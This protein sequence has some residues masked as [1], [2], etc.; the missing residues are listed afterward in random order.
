[1]TEQTNSHFKALDMETFHSLQRFRDAMDDYKDKNP[2]IGDLRQNPAL[3]SKVYSK[4][5][6]VDDKLSGMS[7]SEKSVYSNK[8]MRAANNAYAL[9]D[10]GIEHYA[11]F[12]YNSPYSSKNVEMI[13]SG[14]SDVFSM[15]GYYARVTLNNSNIS[16]N[17]AKMG[18]GQKYSTLSEFG[19][20]FK[21]DSV[22]LKNV[23]GVQAC[24]QKTDEGCSITNIAFKADVVPIVWVE[25]RDIKFVGY[26]PNMST[27]KG[28][29]YG[30]LTEETLS[31]HHH[32]C[33]FLMNNASQLHSNAF[34]NDT[35]LQAVREGK[36]ILAKMA[37][38][39]S[40]EKAMPDMLRFPYAM[41]VNTTSAVKETETI[42]QKSNPETEN[43][44][45]LAT[46]YDEHDF[47]GSVVEDTLNLLEQNGNFSLKSCDGY[48]GTSH[49]ES[50]TKE[51]AEEIINCAATTTR[52]DDWFLN[53]DGKAYYENMQAS[54]SAEMP[55]EASVKRYNADFSKKSGNSRENVEMIAVIKPGH[56]YY[57]PDADGNKKLAAVYVDTQVNNSHL[58]QADIAA[59]NGQKN[60]HLFNEAKNGKFNSSVPWSP[61]QI[62]KLKETCGADAYTAKNG[63][64]Y[65]PLKADVMP[66]T[67]TVDGKQ[68]TIGYMPNTKT[69]QPS[70][71][72]SLT[73]DDIA[74]H[75]D[76]SKALSSAK[77]EKT[78][79]VSVESKNPEKNVQFGE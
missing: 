76:N 16:E 79:G 61:S 66:M 48:D 51:K 77:F 62:A 28:T 52:I 32:N 37:A 25:A 71:Y 8:L 5:F 30:E 72:G 23:R 26:M 70:D 41:A 39:P 20:A 46:R 9:D 36:N 42:K 63:T 24:E 78:V 3:L 2:D 44:K 49:V 33:K 59:G 73:K 54:K 14:E 50:I 47:G 55:A 21:D 31:K 58:T 7:I 35:G 11:D 43:I 13:F 69:I 19:T 29:D 1:M 40:N 17:D 45:I 60:A 67:R 57:K 75:F 65:I 12:S 18:K 6:G 68:T 38:M 34:E 74:K 56:E 15:Q 10:S 64:M 22:K 4:A 53:K 27:V